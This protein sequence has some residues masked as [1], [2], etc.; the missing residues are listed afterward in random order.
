MS[1]LNKFINF[2]LLVSISF[3]G[4]TAC[5]DSEKATSLVGPT[6]KWFN[7]SQHSPVT[8]TNKVT[9]LV[10][11]TTN[12]EGCS[13]LAPILKK[14]GNEYAN[15]IQLIG[16]F[17]PQVSHPITEQ[18]ARNY[19]TRNL[20]ILYPII[21]DTDAKILDSYRINGWPT[22]ILID[23]KGFI[24]KRIYGVKSSQYFYTQIQE[25]LN[26]ERT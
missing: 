8:F 21:F 15:R 2:I 13:Q 5:T 25:V 19:V 20:G 24:Q 16:I 11:L 23:K 18:S 7:A 4:I 26:G 1:N 3:L 9:L 17:T 22:T 12:C 10:F 14:I 6:I